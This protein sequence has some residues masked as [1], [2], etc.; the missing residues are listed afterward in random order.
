MLRGKIIE[1]VINHLLKFGVKECRMDAIASHLRV[2]KKTVYD[3]FGSKQNLIHECIGE[4]INYYKKQFEEAQDNCDSPLQ[5]IM[6][7]NDISLKQALGC[8]PSFYSDIEADAELSGLFSRD[9]IVSIKDSYYR[10]FAR[11]IDMGFFPSEINIDH[12]LNFFEQQIRIMS[13]ENY[14]D[15]MRKMENYSFVILTHLSGICT[16]KGREALLAISTK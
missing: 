9:Y 1:V 13:K 12:T 6:K 2:S 15:A 16:D 3:L 8:S 4:L 5:S 7:I 10:Q 14:M 11:A